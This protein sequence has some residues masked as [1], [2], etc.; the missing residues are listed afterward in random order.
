MEDPKIQRQFILP[1]ALIALAW[2]LA[3]LLGSSEIASGAIW[4]ILGGYLLVKVAG[5]EEAIKKFYTDLLTVTSERVPLYSYAW[6]IAALM[7]IVGLTQGLDQMQEAANSGGGIL[8]MVLA[9]LSLDGILLLSLFALVIIEV[10][11]T[12][13]TYLRDGVFNINIVRFIFTVSSM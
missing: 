3:S 8:G 5:W 9:F 1:M 7:M 11:R 2:G 10:A 4:V 12:T 6:L 13:D